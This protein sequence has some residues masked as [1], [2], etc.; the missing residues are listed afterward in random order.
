[1]IHHTHNHHLFQLQTTS[2]FA[3]PG[4]VAVNSRSG[5]IYVADTGHG[6]VL[7]FN[8]HGRYVS[9]FQQQRGYGPNPAGLA[10][11]PSG[12]VYVGE[13]D[14]G[15]VFRY[16]A[17]GKY[18]SRFRGGGPTVAID[19]ST[20]TIFMPYGTEIAKYDAAGHLVVKFWDHA[21][22]IAGVTYQD[23]AVDPI[24]HDL[25]ATYATTQQFG[26]VKFNPSGVPLLVFG[27]AKGSG[28]GAFG[29]PAGVAVDSHGDV[30][31][32]DGGNHRVEK[33]NSAGTYLGEVGRAA[34]GKAS[35][36]AI[37][38]DRSGALYIVSVTVG[39]VGG[40]QAVIKLGPTGR[41]LGEITGT[42]GGFH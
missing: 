33:F 29:Y 15:Y 11:A 23:V 40:K 10:V 12:D 9:Q 8:R 18:L 16:S 21:H 19:P 27:T 24:S 7:M 34:L 42:T 35:P 4:G 20:G 3:N 41:Y 37:A 14:S 25:Y 30:Y 28:A 2:T 32:G 39:V 5:T 13:L 26:V 31:V 38:T 1:M 17:S 22:G 36:V 6:R